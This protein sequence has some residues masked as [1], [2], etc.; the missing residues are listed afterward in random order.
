MAFTPLTGLWKK[1]KDGK[2]YYSGK[3]NEAVSFPGGVIPKGT[4]FQFWWSDK[5][6]GH[7]NDRDARL[8]ADFEVQPQ[9]AASRAPASAPASTEPA[10]PF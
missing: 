9:Q 1:D 3:T 5:R 10:D 4:T 7:D 6:P 2:E 8:V